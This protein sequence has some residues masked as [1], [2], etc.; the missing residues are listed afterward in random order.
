MKLTNNGD[1]QLV[2]ALDVA[3]KVSGIAIYYQ[4]VLIATWSVILN[5]ELKFGANKLVADLQIINQLFNDKLI[6]WYLSSFFSKD[7][8][9]LF[10]CF[11]S[12]CRF[13]RSALIVLTSLKIW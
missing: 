8:I 7:L 10:N 6:A 3:T 11:C 2:I 12:N 4:Q 5:P 13:A 1:C 9:A